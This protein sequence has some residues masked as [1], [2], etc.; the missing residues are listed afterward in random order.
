MISQR[1][2]QCREGLHALPQIMF[3]RFSKW[4][5]HFK[6]VVVFF[7]KRLGHFSRE[8]MKPSPALGKYD[9]CM[10]CTLKNSCH[11]FYDMEPIK[12]IMGFFVKQDVL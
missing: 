9:Q 2:C 4:W 3:D 7:P 5:W 11:K 12:K 8:G 1:W 6:M 10:I